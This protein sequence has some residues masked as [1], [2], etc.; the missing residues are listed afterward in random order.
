MGKLVRRGLGATVICLALLASACSSSSKS[1]TSSATTSTSVSGTTSTSVGN[2]DFC[3]ARASLKSSLDDL[4]N[5]NI[6]KD[7]TTA[8]Q[9]QV[10]TIKGE[11]AKLK[12]AAGDALQPQIT[13]F[14]KALDSLGD[15]VS[16]VG[17]GGVAAV[18]SAA[19]QVASSGVI[20]L[21]SLDA[22]RCGS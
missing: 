17:S 8:I 6:L 10:T 7:G 21:N 13:S 22:V 15:A 19:T 5:V 11:V 3:A 1:T 9:A 2:A 12:S 18:I 16:N 20:L 4:K 14:Q